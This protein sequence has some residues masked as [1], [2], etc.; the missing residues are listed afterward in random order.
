MIIWLLCVCFFSVSCFLLRIVSAL[1]ARSH[2]FALISSPTAVTKCRMNARVLFCFLWSEANEEMSKKCCNTVTMEI[3]FHTHQAGGVKINI[4]SMFASSASSPDMRS[5]RNCLKVLHFSNLL[6][7]QAK[8][9][10]FH[11]AQSLF[12]AV[13]TIH[14]SSSSSSVPF[15]SH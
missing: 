15:F 1:T 7:H 2:F 5:S 8:Q 10:L 9:V 14:A 3:L 11:K 12:G 13:H 6:Y 4:E